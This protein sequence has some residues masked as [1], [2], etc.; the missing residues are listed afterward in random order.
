MADWRKA[1]GATGRLI[2]DGWLMIGVTILMFVMLEWG[3]RLVAGPEFRVQRVTQVPPGHPYENV[4]WF[5]E[6]NEGGSGPNGRRFLVDPYRFHRLGPMHTKFLT[7]DSLGHRQTVNIMRDSATALRVFM[8][9]GS[10]MWGFTARDS[11]TIPSH[12]AAALRQRGF[13]NVEVKN[14]AEAGYNTTQEAT[15]VLYE[16]AQGRVPTVAVFLNGY[17]DMATAFKW[18]EP[19]HVFELDL[20][21]KKVDAFRRGFAGDLLDL[22]LHSRLIKRLL[23]PPLEEDVPPVDKPTVCAAVADYYRRIALSMRG[24]GQA[25]GFEVFYFLQPVH[26]M[27]RKPLSGFEKTLRVEPAFQ[28]CASAIDSAMHDW[29]GQHYFQAYQWLDSYQEGAFVDRN[30]HITEAANQVIAERIADAIEPALRAKLP[31]RP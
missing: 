5:K 27:T 2:R 31:A 26:H 12:V 10:A 9:G 21:Q 14:L 7:V 19:G 20:T 22:S 11:F 1:A 24:L 13:D 16:I 29:L 23:P 28:A 30:S 3:Y 25:H 6:F 4:E 17:N 15:T 18:G 8:L